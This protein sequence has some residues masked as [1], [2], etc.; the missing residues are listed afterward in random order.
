MPF[1]T[2]TLAHLN[3]ADVNSALDAV[4]WYFGSQ[5]ANVVLASP[6]GKR[7]SPDFRVL[8]LADLPD[9]SALSVLGRSA[10]SVGD[11]ASIA[12]TAASGA[13]LRESGSILGFGTIATAGLAD[14]SVTNAKIRDSSA[15]SVIGRSAN[16]TGDPADIS[17]T[18]ATDAV[19]RESGSVLGFGTVATG[20]IAN[21]AVTDAKLR[22]SAAVSVI[23]RSA[24]S[25]GD[26]ADIA[27]A[28]D[29][30]LLM[31][32]SSTIAFGTTIQAAITFSPAS[33]ND[34]VNVTA[35]QI[36]SSSQFGTRLELTLDQSITTAS[37]T[38]LAN[39]GESFDRGACHDTGTNPSRITVPTGGAGIW[40]FLAGV[41]FAS[42]GGAR[43]EIYIR[44]NGSGN[45]AIMQVT[46]IAATITWLSTATLL[47]LSDAD[48][49]EAVVFQNSGAGL[50]ANASGATF[51][52]GMKL[53]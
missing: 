39:W 2:I 45:T 40:L 13:V 36:E 4:E 50:N 37:A 33:G 21:D 20:G 19:L 27:A 25:S 7:G 46:P 15:L 8:V 53:F 43:R 11:M 42:G 49:V 3:L 51:F 34:A 14:N 9:G 5:P 52:C 38:A 31:R 47:S 26:P 10:N 41:E 28:S 23:G 44:L 1:P 22:N 6:D 32:T 30:Q 29:G 24:N 12:A 16:S 17:A 35:G 48:Y 18:A